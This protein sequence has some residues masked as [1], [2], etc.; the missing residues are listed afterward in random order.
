MSFAPDFVAVTV[1]THLVLANL[2]F[3]S[4]DIQSEPLI[5]WSRSCHIGWEWATPRAF[6]RSLKLKLKVRLEK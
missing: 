2:T 3:A 6:S 4:R 5:K 1:S